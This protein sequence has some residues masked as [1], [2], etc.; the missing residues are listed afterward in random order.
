LP[1]G[2]TR[3][4]DAADRSAALGQPPVGGGHRGSSHCPG[5]P[6]MA[7]EQLVSVL[8]RFGPGLGV[9]Y[10]R[11]CP[12][13]RGWRKHSRRSPAGTFGLDGTP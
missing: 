8:L 7:A 11:V 4:Q 5:A 1:Q 9:A 3:D 6:G 13:P 12:L 10:F 2:V